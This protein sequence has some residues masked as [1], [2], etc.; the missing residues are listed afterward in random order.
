MIITRVITDQNVH[1]VAVDIAKMKTAES[2][3]IT[4]FAKGEFKTYNDFLKFK[5]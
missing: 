2:M 5:R 1:I 3:E 4:R